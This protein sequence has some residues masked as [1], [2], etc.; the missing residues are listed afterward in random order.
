[1][2]DHQDYFWFDQ[3]FV[4]PICWSYINM[5]FFVCEKLNGNVRALLWIFPYLLFW[6]ELK[7]LFLTRLQTIIIFIC[8]VR[9]FIHFLIEFTIIV[10]I[11]ISFLKV[12]FP[13]R[14][15]GKVYLKLNFIFLIHLND[16][17]GYSLFSNLVN[18]I[19]CGCFRYC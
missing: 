16:F 18:F 19:W 9:F 17:L 4:L 11:S 14:I 12:K 3:A 8:A 1:M 2:I 7:I 6:V 13:A 5:V 15:I 10:F